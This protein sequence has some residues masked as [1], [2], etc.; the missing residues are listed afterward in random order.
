M[1]GTLTGG[2]SGCVVEQVSSHHLLHYT[3][4]AASDWAS[5]VMSFSEIVQ[6]KAAGSGKRTRIESIGQ[7]YSS[8]CF[9]SLSEQILYSTRRGV[10]PTVSKSIGSGVSFL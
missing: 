9:L 4:P 10:M 8:V 7:K 2:E 3:K 5:F 6:R 1:Y